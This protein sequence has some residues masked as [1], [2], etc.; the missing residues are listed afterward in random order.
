[1]GVDEESREV[2]NVLSLS[3]TAALNDRPASVDSLKFSDYTDALYEFITHEKTIPPLTISIDG[4][5]G[6]GKSSFMLQLEQRLRED[7]HFT[8]RFNPWLHQETDALWGAFMLSFLQQLTGDLSLVDRLRGQLRLYWL[9]TRRDWSR[10]QSALRFFAVA[11][12]SIAVLG[13]VVLTTWA[14][15]PAV[16]VTLLAGVGVPVDL[17]GLALLGARGFSGLFG[18]AA[19]AAVL[20]RWSAR[21]VVDPVQSE[22]QSYLIS[23]RYEDHISFIECFHDDL[24]LALEA[25]TGPHCRRVFVFI[26]DLD[27]CDV[28]QAAV[29]MESINLLLSDDPRL[30]FLIGMDRQK[31]SAGIAAKHEKVLEHLSDEYVESGT[32][33]GVD[34]GDDFIDK[35][36]QVPFAI[37]RPETFDEFGLRTDDTDT[38]EGGT[39]ALERIVKKLLAVPVL[40]RTARTFVGV[41]R[42]VVW[43][44]EAPASPRAYRL[45]PRRRRD[46][47]EE[48][49]ADDEQP[50]CLDRA[51]PMPETTRHGLAGPLDPFRRPPPALNA[52]AITDEVLPSSRRKE[53]LRRA[54]RTLEYNPRRF[55]KFVNLFRLYGL[56]ACRTGVLA[57]DDHAERAPL[58]TSKK[59]SPSRDEETHQKVTVDQLG[60]FVAIR[61]RW[62]RLVGELHDD[63][64]LLA[65][66][67][68]I[69]I[70][71]KYWEDVREVLKD[72]PSVVD[73]CRG[74]WR[75]VHAGL[76]GTVRRREFETPDEAGG[77][78]EDSTTRPTKYSMFPRWGYWKELHANVS[79]WRGR[80]E[81][82]ISAEE[83][84]RVDE[85][86]RALERERLPESVPSGSEFVRLS[87]LLLHGLFPAEATPGDG[88]PLVP[89]PELDSIESFP[90]WKDVTEAKRDGESSA[91]H[92]DVA[93]ALIE[94]FGTSSFLDVRAAGEE[95]L[96]ARFRD[97]VTE[98][99]KKRFERALELNGAASLLRVD[100]KKLL[101]ISEVDTERSLADE[102]EELSEE[103]YREYEAMDYAAAVEKY[104]ESLHLYFEIG[105]RHNESVT[106]Y[107]LGVA[108]EMDGRFEYAAWCYESC[109]S[110]AEAAG[111]RANQV[112]GLLARGKLHFRRKEYDDA[113]ARYEQAYGV[114]SDAG[115]HE[116][117]ANSLVSQGGVYE[118]IFEYDIARDRYESARSIATANYL[119]EPRASSLFGLGSVHLGLEAFEGARQYYQ[120]ALTEFDGLRDDANVAY[121]LGNLGIIAAE[122]G[123]TDTAR[124]YFEWSLDIQ[125]GLPE[126]Y[127]YNGA[128][129]TTLE[130]AGKMFLEV[131]E[132]DRARTRLEESREFYEMDEEL[133]G[134]AKVHA[135]L[136]EIAEEEG[137][138]TTART[139][140]AESL[141]TRWTDLSSR[142]V[143]GSDDTRCDESTIADALERRDHQTV[144][145]CFDGL[146]ARRDERQY[147]AARATVF[148][149]LGAL[150]YVDDE[151]ARARSFYTTSL[152]LYRQVGSRLR[153]AKVL[154]RLAAVETD[155]LRARDHL[156][157]S[158]DCYRTLG[159]TL[160]EAK[161]LD[162][163][164][165]TS[166]KLGDESAAQTHARARVSLAVDDTDA[167]DG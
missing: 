55:K 139:H 34:F 166:V 40:G 58:A 77:A 25:Y 140:Y 72:N 17:T 46:P 81:F 145:Q 52:T 66:L 95:G 146:L 98:G 108:G 79:D 63:P 100:S 135:L 132:T 49:R 67:T 165:D 155:P 19:W 78:D 47:A 35:F 118:T 71:R 113:V 10:A 120:E 85:E 102:A 54:E 101:H 137:D 157:R 2:E 99:E 92:V 110:L 121:S 112:T 114:A 11:V 106:L 88:E 74:I 138:D 91:P 41:Y 87:H 18:F 80:R 68:V 163:L 84:D 160:K 126:H 3:M 29:L 27:R 109:A 62:K 36:I 33:P 82:E 161:T 115:D 111:L 7:G 152:G 56:V 60:K 107:N 57:T 94:F 147:L 142:P 43:D 130:V 22:L 76:G 167:R 154:D 50:E 75:D 70:R 133:D 61:L 37:P 31:V 6:V 42:Y 90:L 97:V 162:R 39:G 103:A 44:P 14:F 127:G 125:E 149:V 26:D 9:G 86:L 21:N 134:I 116:G 104:A 15:G 8:V 24:S 119:R 117:M 131:G 48:T 93:E 153:Q 32:S 83:W 59:N 23:P 150:A 122:V 136:G 105:D 128:R 143:P 158:L 45:L 20:W 96:D 148:D 5:W 156:E 51:P 124:Q 30:V 53:I 123:E 1:M 159:A 4:E 65:E 13:A 16:V 64:D 12:V 28:P 38:E 144:Q 69:T 164:V 89:T 151:H 141:R 129:G 73:M